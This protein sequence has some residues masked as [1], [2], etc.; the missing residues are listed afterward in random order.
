MPSKGDLKAPSKSASKSA[1]QECPSVL[2]SVSSKSVKRACPAK[3]S[4]KSV[5]QECPARVS[6]KG[7]LSRESCLFNLSLP[8]ERPQHPQLVLHFSAYL[9]LPM[10]AHEHDIRL[11]LSLLFARQMTND[12]AVVED[13]LRLNPLKTKVLVV[14]IWFPH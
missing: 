9:L 4:R 7:A 1:K 6:S 13:G 10:L 8:R 14:A 12:P 11:N 2:T 5:E 3:V